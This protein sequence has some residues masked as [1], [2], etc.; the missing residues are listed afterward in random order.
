[1]SWWGWVVVGAILLGAELALVNVEFYFVCIGSAA[2]LTGLVE[3]LVPGSAPWMQWALFTSLVLLSLLA[4]RRRV[5]DLVKGHQ[6]G[7]D[8]G[9][10]AGGVLVVP[11]ILAPGQTCQAE[12][13][14][15]FWTIRN[16]GPVVL[17][18]GAKAR[19]ECVDGLTLVLQATA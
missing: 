18:A 6:L 7:V 13:A 5:R 9:P 15:S 16:D 2:I 4:F 10:A 14:G 12:H 11:V 17:Q 19:I 8:A 3:A 1:M